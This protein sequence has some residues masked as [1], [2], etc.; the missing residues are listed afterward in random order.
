MSRPLGDVSRW[1]K[2]N[3]RLNL[4]NRF[5]PM[6]PPHNTSEVQTTETS[7]TNTGTS[8]TATSNTSEQVSTNTATSN[9]KY[10][11][12]RDVLIQ[13][14]AVF[15]GGYAC[16][17]YARYMSH[18]GKNFIYRADPDF[19]AY[20]EDPERCAKKVTAQL[21]KAGIHDVFVQTNPPVGE[22]VP[23]SYTVLQ[24]GVPIATLFGTT[25]CHN[26]NRIRL[27]RY[28]VH[29]ATIDTM[30]NFLLALYYTRKDADKNRLYGMAYHLLHVQQ[31]TKLLQ[32]GILKR[33]NSSC[34]GKQQTL[35]DMKAEKGRIVKEY[36]DKKKDA[37][38]DLHMF[39]YVPK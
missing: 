36:K 7:K 30:L 31:K 23:P 21:E 15:F 35:G 4:L 19:D 20:M 6:K 37:E 27:G 14:G 24:N 12:V 38:Y 9:A 13:E 25:G 16:S 2:V 8:K 22:I 10:G 39:K 32:K 33:F 34:A 18:S 1:E 17:L 26:Y 5:Y 11:I 3:K 29:V 28:S